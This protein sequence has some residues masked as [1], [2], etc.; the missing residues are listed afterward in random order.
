MI[1]YKPRLRRAALVLSTLFLVCGLFSCRRVPEAGRPLPEQGSSATERSEDPLNLRPGLKIILLQNLPSPGNQALRLSD[2][3][4]ELEIL[5][6]PTSEGLTFQWTLKIEP[7]S[8]PIANPETAPSLRE[9]GTMTLANL[10]GSRA[11]TLPL[12]W[13][14]GELFLSNSSALW[15]SDRAFEDLKKKRRSEWQL[16][17]LGNSLLGAVQGTALLEKPLEAAT[18]GLQGDPEKAQSSQSIEVWDKNSS[19]SLK[20]NGHPRE[21]PTLIAGNWLAEYTI[22]DNPQNPLILQVRILPKA[23]PADVLFSPLTWVKPFLD[24]H[25][26]ELEAPVPVLRLSPSSSL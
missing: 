3:R 2:V 14:Q 7:S 10:V 4:R 8:G 6:F 16:G 18:A 12:F 19:Y 24:Y 11:M 1:P 13:P 22:L 20:V 21:V 5:T 9:E 25:V 26:G 15:V 23:R 17:I